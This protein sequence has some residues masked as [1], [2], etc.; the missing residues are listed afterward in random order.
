MIGCVAV[1]RHAVNRL[2]FCSNICTYGGMGCLRCLPVIIVG[3]REKESGVSSFN[4]CCSSSSSWV[5]PLVQSTSDV[6]CTT[7]ADSTR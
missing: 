6:L 4:L 1:I 7:S 3:G 2:L 5:E